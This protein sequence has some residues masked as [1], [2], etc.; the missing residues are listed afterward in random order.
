MGVGALRRTAELL[1]EHGRDAACPVAVVERGFEPTQRTTFG[2]LHTIA[3]RAEAV[4]VESPAVIVVGDVV[5]LSP[6]YQEAS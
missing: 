2:D 5:R 3:D 6:D 4:G 1:V